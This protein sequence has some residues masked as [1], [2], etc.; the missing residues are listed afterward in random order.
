L[1]KVAIFYILNAKDDINYAICK[2]IKKYFEQEKRVIVSS[3]DQNVINNINNLLWTFEQLS[4]IPHCIEKD[5]D[6]LTPVLLMDT[7]F[8]NDSISKKD[9]NIFIN[10][11][12]EEKT[13]YHDH[14]VIVE[15]VSDNERIKKLAREKY[16]YYKKNKLNV[17]HENL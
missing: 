15:V 7:N 17:K 3:K 13:D 14:D 11:D 9:Y 6:S 1:D 5:Y 8:K 2:I 12:D 10:L 16:L 4:F